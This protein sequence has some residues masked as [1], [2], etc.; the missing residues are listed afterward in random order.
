M[1]LPTRPTQACLPLACTRCRHSHLARGAP[2]PTGL[3]RGAR[4]VRLGLPARRGE[5]CRDDRNSQ[6][7]PGGVAG[8]PALAC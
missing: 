7:R 8:L 1:L 4:L 5:G 6:G 3:A 2:H